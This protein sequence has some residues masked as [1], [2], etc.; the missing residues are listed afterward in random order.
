M[1]DLVRVLVRTNSLLLGWYDVYTVSFRDEDAY[2][3]NS[4]LLRDSFTWPTEVA[5]VQSQCSELLVAT[6]YTDFVDTFCA[7]TSVGGLTAE[8]KLSLLAVGSAVSTGGGT[9]MTRVTRDTHPNILLAQ[10]TTDGVGGASTLRCGIGLL[11]L[12]MCGAG[13]GGLGQVSIVTA[14]Y[15][16]EATRV[17]PQHT[18]VDLMS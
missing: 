15:P 8:F 17:K 9:L 4:S 7:D 11:K 13:D 2:S 14:F 3:D 18:S 16:R 6:S 12:V 10:E 5:S 1:A